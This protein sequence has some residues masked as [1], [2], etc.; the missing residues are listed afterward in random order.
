[1]GG[2]RAAGGRGERSVSFHVQPKNYYRNVS[3]N[4]EISKLV[5]LLSTA[6]NSTKKVCGGRG[7]G[8]RVRGG[9]GQGAGCIGVG[10]GVRM[11][12]SV[13]AGQGAWGVGSRIR[14]CGGGVVGH[15][16]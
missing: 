3:E 13:V 16:A 5:S 1:M 10:S 8:V 12:G 14:V 6:I 9:Q 2:L 4:K 7:S 11:H 15:G